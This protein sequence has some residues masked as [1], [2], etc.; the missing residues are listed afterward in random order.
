MVV[1]GGWQLLSVCVCVC[2]FIYSRMSKNCK[3]N[4]LYNFKKFNCYNMF[5]FHIPVIHMHL[6]SLHIVYLVLQM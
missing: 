5:Y 4:C 2:V 3:D 6:G 1:G